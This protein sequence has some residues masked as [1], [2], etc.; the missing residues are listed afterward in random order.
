MTDYLLLCAIHQRGLA[1]SSG[2]H[3][4]GLPGGATITVSETFAVM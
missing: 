2:R 3:R 1:R 4:E